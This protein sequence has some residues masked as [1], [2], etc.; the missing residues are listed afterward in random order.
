MFAT[1]GKAD[2]N[3]VRYVGH[4]V[5]IEDDVFRLRRRALEFHGDT[6]GF[7]DGAAG[8]HG[9][10]RRLRRGKSRRRRQA[11]GPASIVAAV[12]GRWR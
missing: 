4:G 8:L 6:A 5:E 12:A 7:G 9:A 11:G 1:T 10:A 2:V 3:T